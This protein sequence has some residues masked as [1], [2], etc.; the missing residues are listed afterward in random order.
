MKEW[1]CQELHLQKAR[2]L[3]SGGPVVKVDGAAKAEENEGI[4]V[5]VVDGCQCSRGH[6]GRFLP[7]S[8]GTASPHLLS[9]FTNTED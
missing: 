4:A 7:D 3:D 1:E 2:K 9:F 5:K 6:S 8:A